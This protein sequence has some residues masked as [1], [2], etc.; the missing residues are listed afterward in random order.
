[1]YGIEADFAAKVEQAFDTMVARF[2][3]EPVA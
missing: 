3:A 1:M 2:A